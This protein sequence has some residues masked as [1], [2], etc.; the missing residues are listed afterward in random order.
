MVQVICITLFGRY[1]I[2]TT[3]GQ[4]PPHDVTIAYLFCSSV[5]IIIIAIDENVIPW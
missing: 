5:I 1:K 3:V 2:Y 4:I